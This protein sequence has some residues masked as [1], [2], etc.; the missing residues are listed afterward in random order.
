[1][2]SEFDIIFIYF[3]CSI[4]RTWFLDISASMLK[5]SWQHVKHIWKVSKW[6]VW[7]GEVFRMLMQVA[8]AAQN[9]SRILW[10]VTSQYLFR[11]FHKLGQRIARSSFPLPVRE[12]IKCL[13]PRTFLPPRTCL[14]I[15]TDLPSQCNFVTKIIILM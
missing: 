13:P 10:L 9:I 8:R 11:H 4:S 15:I 2:L 5:I 12:T 7:P 1:M 14:I 3:G 6:D